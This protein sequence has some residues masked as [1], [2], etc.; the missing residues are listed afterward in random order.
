MALHPASWKRFVLYFHM[1][2]SFEFLLQV[3]SMCLIF[4]RIC[5]SVGQVMCPHNPGKT[6]LSQFTRFFSDN[7]CP[8]LTCLGKWGGGGGGG[9]VAQSGHCLFFYCNSYKGFPKCVCQCHCHCHH[10]DQCL[11]GHKCLG[12]LSERVLYMCLSLSLSL[13]LYL[14]LSSSFC[15]SGHVSSSPWSNVSKVTSL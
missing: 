3:F 6:H 8:L 14:S 15:W 1:F 7:I 13:S 10:S 4:Y 11:K 12:S 2:V 9:G 5:L